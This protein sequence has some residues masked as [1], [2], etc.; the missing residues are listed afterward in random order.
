MGV[1]KPGS[2]NPAAR[3]QEHNFDGT[4]KLSMTQTVPDLPVASASNSATGTASPTASALPLPVPSSGSSNEPDLVI[5]YSSVEKKYIA[6]GILTGLGFCFFLPIGVLQ[7]RFL[8]IWWPRWFKAHWVVQAG[9]AGPFIVV[10]C[11]LAVKA[12]WETGGRHFDDKHMIIG[13]VL[14]LLY[15]CQ[16]LYGFVIHVVKDPNRKRRLV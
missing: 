10:G 1:H 13:L 8:R 7:A 15:A 6:H 5:P 3:I 11:G 9:L 2:S 4:F 14:F 12:V 16:A